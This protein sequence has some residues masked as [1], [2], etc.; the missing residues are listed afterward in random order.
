MPRFI[1]DDDLMFAPQIRE[2]EYQQMHKA[3]EGQEQDDHKAVEEVELNPERKRRDRRYIGL[4][5]E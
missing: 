1:P 5:F 3:R 2:R 4:E